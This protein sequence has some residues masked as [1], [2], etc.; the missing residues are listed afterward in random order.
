MGGRVGFF[1]PSL[2]DC[3]MPASSAYTFC[4]TSCHNESGSWPCGMDGLTYGN[5]VEGFGKEMHWG[6]GGKIR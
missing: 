4:A 3:R 2:S 6:G 1:K 5:M